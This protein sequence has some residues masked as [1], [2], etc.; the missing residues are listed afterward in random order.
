MKLSR[1]E[2]RAAVPKRV[3]L[4]IES[5]SD[6]PVAYLTL[7]WVYQGQGAWME[8]L[9]ACR[10]RSLKGD[11]FVLVG[12]ERVGKFWEERWLPQAWWCRLPPGAAA[13][14]PPEA[15][16]LALLR[17]NPHPSPAPAELKRPGGERLV[18]S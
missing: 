9:K 6:G 17:P 5:A 14:P 1:D 18:T 15:D 11:A 4:S 2:L 7:P 16:P 13:A 12:R 10:I 3:E 8:S